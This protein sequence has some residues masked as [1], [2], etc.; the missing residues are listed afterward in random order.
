MCRGMRIRL[1]LSVWMV[2][3]VHFNPEHDGANRYVYLMTALAEHRSIA[4]EGQDIVYHAD[5]MEMGG[6]SYCNNNPGIAFMAVPFWWPLSLLPLPVNPYVRYFIAHFVAFATITATASALAAVLIAEIVFDGTRSTGRAVFA[7]LLYAFGTIAFHF[8]THLNQNMVVTTFGLLIFCLL[9]RPHLLGV[10]A[11][12]FRCFLIGVLGGLALFVDMS[13]LPFLAAVSIPV[14]YLA[15]GVRGLG[16]LVAGALP[17]LVALAGYQQMAFG[18]P[19]LPPQSYYEIAGRAGALDAIRTPNLRIFLDNTVLP[20]QGL[21]WFMPFSVMA[22]YYLARNA[23]S[24]S[25]EDRTAAAVVL[26]Y[27]VYVLLNVSAKF[28]QFGPRY[29]MPAVPF[30]VLAF[31]RDLPPARFQLGGVLAG[32]SF[33]VNLAGAQLGYGTFNLPEYLALYVL[34]GPWLPIFDWLQSPAFTSTGWKL[35]HIGS[36]LGPFVLLLG[37]E[38]SMWLPF[39][40]RLPRPLVSTNEGARGE[41]PGQDGSQPGQA[42]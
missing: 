26:L 25:G 3:L 13:L 23:V 33:F 21:L 40:L 14:L 6:H 2:Y 36:P 37:A 5:L 28:S 12:G 16:F 30:L 42:H 15:G 35:P 27:L 9:Y 18:N 24:R 19:L 17:P 29:I 10:H 39:V 38:L 8:S 22:V 7:C 41:I 1:F 4:V 11:A 20:T 34:R 31:C 32:M